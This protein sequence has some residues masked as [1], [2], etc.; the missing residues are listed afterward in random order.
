M[1]ID[2]LEFNKITL[3]VALIIFFHKHLLQK[4]KIGRIATKN[5]LPK[6]SRQVKQLDSNC[7]NG[8]SKYLGACAQ[9]PKKKKRPGW[10]YSRIQ[11]LEREWTL[12]LV[13]CVEPGYPRGIHWVALATIVL[14]IGKAFLVRLYYK[15]LPLASTCCKLYPHTEY[16]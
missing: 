10:V 6:I 7:Y 11:W 2:H 3:F 9:A 8:V 4:S 1:V 13:Q 15:V 5:V 14:C 16:Y 12:K